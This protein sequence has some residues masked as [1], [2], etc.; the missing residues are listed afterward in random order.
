[1]SPKANGSQ[2]HEQENWKDRPGD[3]QSFASMANEHRIA[4]ERTTAFIDEHYQPIGTI[5]S[6]TI[7]RGTAHPSSDLDM[8]VAH[9]PGW[10]QRHQRWENG[11]PIEIF[12]N[13]IAEI[14]RTMQRDVESGRPVMIHMIATGIIVHDTNDTMRRL[15]HDARQRLRG[16]PLVPD[17]ALTA[18]R[19]A[20][21]TECED[22]LDILQED[23]DR[24]G[25]M[26][27][28][29]LLQ[30]IRLRFLQEGRW[31]PREKQLLGALDD[32]DRDLGLACREA[33][34]PIPAERVRLSQPII[35]G[36]A[37]SSRFFAWESS[38]QET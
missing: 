16:G 30:A 36:I 18:M 7:I 12:V 15:Q 17:E 4:L 1:M 10:R 19:Y 22:A 28:S 38:R 5:A 37:G 21:A 31:L 9:L 29:S 13:P 26:A 32:L 2:T 25:A 20:I 24:A 27:T 33:L 35:E 14:E 6:G 3:N 11:V 8:V 34:R 23:A